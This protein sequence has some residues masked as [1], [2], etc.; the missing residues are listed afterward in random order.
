MIMMVQHNN[1]CWD[2][3]LFATYSPKFTT[4]SPCFILIFW[5]IT[6]ARFLLGEK[7][8]QLALAF[9]CHK[10]FLK[11]DYLS[12]QINLHIYTVLHT[13]CWF[14]C[15]CGAV[16]YWCLILFNCFFGLGSCLLTVPSVCPFVVLCDGLSC[17][18][19]VSVDSIFGCCVLMVL[20]SLLS[21]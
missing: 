15:C 20:E 13:R 9:R 8:L 17:L 12:C 5:N 21:F 19:Y 10:I 14:C 3:F 7:M 4:N 18:V 6:V 16:H 1:L 11:M 2:F